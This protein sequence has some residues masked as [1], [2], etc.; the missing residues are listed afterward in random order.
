M[1]GD[2]PRFSQEGDHSIGSNSA[3]PFTE[4][5]RWAAQMKEAQNYSRLY[6]GISP[7]C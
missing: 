6:T 3:S 4:Y 1:H 5:H 7:K 2:K